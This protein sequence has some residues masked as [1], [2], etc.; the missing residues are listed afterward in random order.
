M[1][2]DG[3]VKVK[4]D[5]KKELADR[6]SKEN[7]TPVFFSI[8]EMI[9][10]I[11]RFPKDPWR[12]G[13]E[14]E[15]EEEKMTDAAMEEET[16]E[17]QVKKKKS[18]QELRAEWNAYTEEKYGPW[19]PIAVACLTRRREACESW[20]KWFYPCDSGE[21]LILMKEERLR[22]LEETQSEPIQELL[23]RI[24]AEE[25]REKEDLQELRELRDAW[26]DMIIRR[27]GKRLHGRDHWQLLFED[28]RPAGPFWDPTPGEDSKITEER[29]NLKKYIRQELGSPTIVSLAG[30]EEVLLRIARDRHDW[31]YHLAGI[32]NQR[33]TRAP[34]DPSSASTSAATSASG[35]SPSSPSIT[36]TSPSASSSS[37]SYRSCSEETSME[38]DATTTED[39]SWSEY[40]DPATELSASHSSESGYSDDPVEFIDQ[41]PDI[42]SP[43]EFRT[44]WIALK[45][46]Y[47]D[48]SFDGS[49]EANASTIKKVV[50]GANQR[51]RQLR[52]DARRWATA[53]AAMSTAVSA[54][55][56]AAA[57]ATAN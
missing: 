7:E 42:P 24:E 36:A 25:A 41:D 35:S 23:Q 1:A 32:D 19:H 27:Y 50:N 10:K 34:G 39:E 12:E 22:W 53:A 44:A 8:P 11:V 2:R 57:S 28:N 17:E 30:V 29:E 21:E 51:A 3:S 45:R 31:G 18:R 14:E 48:Q 26:N 33:L 54:A 20:N 43:D 55:E 40:S 56:S 37:S 49:T 38:E 6:W 52:S 13:E 9:S 5:R 47:C 16:K 15:E 4:M 46:Q